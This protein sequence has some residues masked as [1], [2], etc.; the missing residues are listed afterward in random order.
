MSY[1]IKKMSDHITKVAKREENFRRPF[2]PFSTARSAFRSF[3]QAAGI[4]CDEVVLL[5]SYIGWS[6]REGSGVFD[7]VLELGLSYRFYRMNDHLQIDLIDLERALQSGKVKV[8]VIIHYFG[9]VDPSYEQAVRLARNYGALVLEDEAHALYSDLIGG[10]CGRLGE[11][12]IFSLHKMLPTETGGLLLANRGWPIPSGEYSGSGDK[13]IMPWEY[14]LHA[15][16]QRR[17][18]NTLQLSGLLGGMVEDIEL[19]WP[20][21]PDHVVPQTLPILIRRVSRDQLYQLMNNEGFGVVSLY[22]SL[23]TPISSAEFS[24]SHGISRQIMNLPVHQDVSADA[25]DLMVEALSRN[26][27][28]LI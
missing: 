22:H 3:L 28:L 27:R 2:S 12:V 7:P 10:V 20:E 25:L 17:R 21:L 11:A 23:V 8:M 4:G 26:I 15:I 18:Q 24:D 6:A 9:Y 19:L 5:P 13:W 14:D 16:A 1:P